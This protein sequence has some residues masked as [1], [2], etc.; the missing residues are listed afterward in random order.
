MKKIFIITISFLLIATAY[1]DNPC[2]SSSGPYGPMACTGG[3][4][5]SISAN[6]PVTINDTIVQ[7][8]TNVN[9]TLTADKA[10]L[11]QLIVNGSVAL[12]SSLVKGVATINGTL[13]ATKTNFEDTI[14]ISTNNATFSQCQAAD[15]IVDNSGDGIVSP[16]TITIDQNSKIDGDITFKGNDGVVNLGPNSTITGKVIG[17]KVVKLPATTNNSDKVTDKTVNAATASAKVNTGS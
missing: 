6:G 5:P 13:T 4:T 14:T 3:V 15:I 12:T 16:Q 7:Q 17:G 1:A 10:T 11:N 9:G 8:A 2:Q